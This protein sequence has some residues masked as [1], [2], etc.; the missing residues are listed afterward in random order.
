MVMVLVM[1]MVIV[2]ILIMMM[3]MILLLLIIIIALRS[4][5][6]DAGQGTRMHAAG[7]ISLLRLSLLR[8]L[9]SDFPGNSQWA[10]EFHPFKSIVFGSFGGRH[11]GLALS[12]DA[13]SRLRFRV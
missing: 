9:N 4:S 2:T 3:M 5:R 7:P 13:N 11:A 1:V 12:R 8:L 10:W 6:V